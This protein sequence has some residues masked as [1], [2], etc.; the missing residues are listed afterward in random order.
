MFRPYRTILSLP[1]AFA[2]SAIGWYARLP[3]S[4]LGIGIVLLVSAKTGSYGLAGTVAATSVLA[5]AAAAPFQARVVDRFGQGRVLPLLAGISGTALSG[6]IVAVQTGAQTPIPHL[7][8]AVAG[9]TGPLIGSYV[10]ARW[11]HLLEGRPELHT[12]F[13][14]EALLDEVVFMV[15]PPVVTLLATAVH[16]TAGLLTAVFTG[17]TGALLFANQRRTEPPANRR[18]S[19]HGAQPPLP[20]ASLGPLTA[21]SAGLGILFGAAEV[22]V[23]AVAS[24]AGQ[25]AMSGVLLALWATGSML[26]ALIVGVVKPRGTLLTR[27][28]VHAGVLALTLVPMP[29]IGHLGLLGGVMFLAGFAISPTL[30]ALM[31]VIARISPA[32]R[33]NEGMAWTH[34]GLAAGVA[35]GAAVAGATG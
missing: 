19:G 23:V 33:L 35:A 24:E 8:A 4:M 12:A 32:T 10:R 26:A 14:L 1:G 13:A 11:T 16:P 29:F 34:A 2:F 27:F 20:W 7:L 28:R 25:R 9:A 5:A 18:Q 17:V 3:M 30:V 15:G 6:L 21:A 22:V 31:A